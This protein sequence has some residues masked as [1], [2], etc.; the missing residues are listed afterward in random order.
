MTYYTKPEKDHSERDFKG[1]QISKYESGKERPNNK[2]LRAIA[3][4]LDTSTHYLLGLTNNSENTIESIIENTDARNRNMYEGFK[5]LF[6][7]IGYDFSIT[8]QYIETPDH[9]IKSKNQSN[10]ITSMFDD[11]C[12]V[13]KDKN[14]KEFVISHLNM[15]RILEMFRLRF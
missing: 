6:K 9:F 3:H 8:D 15:I 12:F 1:S 11:Y 10:S 5:Y 4:I 14:G 2:R 7:S 13:L